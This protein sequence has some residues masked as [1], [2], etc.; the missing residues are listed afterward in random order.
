MINYPI[1][2][3]KRI[4]VH[5]SNFKT[6]LSGYLFKDL[7]NKSL[8]ISVITNCFLFLVL[9][10][11]ATPVYR[12]NDD[13]VLNLVS[14]GFF[15]KANAEF[16]LFG[17][18]LYGKL[19][20]LLYT[21][22]PHFNWYLLSLVFF[23]FISYV[24][25]LYYLL[26]INRRLFTI[27]IYVS[28]FLIF[29][30]NMFAEINFSGTSLIALSSSL[31]IL[32]SILN[33][34]GTNIPDYVLFILT[35]VISIA[36]RKDSFYIFCYIFLLFPIFYYIRWR[37]V[38]FVFALSFVCF[39]S[40]YIYN[41]RYY[42]E[43][44]PLQIE[45]RKAGRLM[46][47]G[48]V[49]PSETELTKRGWDQEDYELFASFKGVDNNFYSKNNVVS[50]AKEIKYKIDFKK[51]LLSPYSL[52]LNV[53]ND[54][55]YYSIGLAL[56]LILF[57]L[58]RKPSRF[59]FVIYSFWILTFFVLG[60]VIVH[61]R[62]YVYYAV[63]FY[64]GTIGAFY[65]IQ[66]SNSRIFQINIK[67]K[68][69]YVILFLIALILITLINIIH[70]KQLLKKDV[71]ADYENKVI[72]LKDSDKKFLIVGQE[73]EYFLGKWSIFKSVKNNSED[74]LRERIVSLG[75]FINTIQF[76]RIVNGSVIQLLLRGD[77]F[78]L[79]EDDQLFKRLEIFI[80]KHYS[81]KVN[82]E[83]INNYKYSKVYKLT[84]N[85]NK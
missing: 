63:L 80:L 60:I 16:L 69:N 45:Y 9:I 41:N 24:L 10:L 30:A 56:I 2:L 68:I 57:Y 62:L 31:L 83:E 23:Q 35:F 8:I 67:R 37:K 20:K 71:F 73:S 49:K 25:I 6:K 42:T 76:E 14:S 3:F 26:K 64:L 65:V 54:I 53:I 21:T 33:K 27:F 36:V 17:N 11:I 78:F 59:F 38:L 75:W 82:F 58:M 43:K 28:L 32:F 55:Y 84:I 61:Y 48:I 13:I 77:I 50:L 74:R 72:E 18:I 52:I 44:D 81:L 66:E 34:K 5:C 29:G 70:N 1:K 15:G 22:G 19:L 79:G 51:I 46:L 7:G 40:L 47:D 4:D 39:A 85:N 12:S